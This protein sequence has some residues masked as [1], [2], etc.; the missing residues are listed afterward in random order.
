MREAGSKIDIQIG[1]NNDIEYRAEIEYRAG[2][3]IDIRF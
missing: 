3:E 1:T 2:S